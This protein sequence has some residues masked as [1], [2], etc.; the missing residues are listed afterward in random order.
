MVELALL[1]AVVAACHPRGDRARHSAESQQSTAARA[2]GASVPGGKAVARAPIEV[3][4][5][6][7]DTLNARRFVAAAYFNRLK[8]QV[9]RR[10]E[11]IPVMKRIDP[12]GS[13]L[14]VKS[15]ITEVRLSLSRGGE[16]VD[17]AVTSSS[18]V[19]GV[20]GL[21]FE[22]VRALLAAAP[23]GP[24]PEFLTEDDGRF[25]FFMSLVVEA[26]ATRITWRLP[27]ETFDTRED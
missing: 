2:S 16:L 10:W 1:V 8:R 9:A 15:R 12:T 20:N 22:G 27:K 13:V 7:E 5:W 6:D 3:P 11:P 4:A 24:P 23:F 26:G 17:V 25:A 19:N 14:G 18:G 21:D